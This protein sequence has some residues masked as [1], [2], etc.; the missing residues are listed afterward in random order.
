ME[1]K[2]ENWARKK[3]ES[4]TETQEG[5]TCG[6]KNNYTHSSKV[7]LKRTGLQEGPK[8]A[9]TSWNREKGVLAKGYG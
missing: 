2:G 1:K 5:S 8:E 6:G 3:V 4:S 7:R 9:E